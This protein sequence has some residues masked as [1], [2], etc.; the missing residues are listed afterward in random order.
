[1]FNEL[2]RRQFLAMLAAAGLSLRIPS[3][4]AAPE[5]HPIVRPIPSSGEQ[6]PAIGMGTWRTF[7]VGGDQYLIDQRT[8]V[9][10]TF[11]N[12]GG[13]LVDCC[14]RAKQHCTNVPTLT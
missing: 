8:Q 7:N 10:E 5:G 14:T 9:L 4:M 6:L 12:L 3:L 2:G 13:T 11:F 1:M